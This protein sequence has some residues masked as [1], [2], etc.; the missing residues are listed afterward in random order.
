[1]VSTKD[2][3]LSCHQEHIHLRICICFSPTR[4]PSWLYVCRHLKCVQHY[5]T[6]CSSSPILTPQLTTTYTVA[7]PSDEAKTPTQE[8]N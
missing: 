8:S 3:D 7:T 6:I 1:M 2:L 5:A 4:S